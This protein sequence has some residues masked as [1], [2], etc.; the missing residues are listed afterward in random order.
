[1]NRKILIGPSSFAET[2][3]TPMKLLVATGYEVVDNPYK[4]RLTKQDLFK[5][6]EKNVV[7]L[8]AGVE[9]L[10]REVLERSDLK[11][12]SRVGS[13]L[14][15]I[16][17]K[18]AEQLGIRVFSTPHGP[19]SAVAELTLGAMLSLIRMVPQM[20]RAL[21]SGKWMK[22]TGSQLEGKTV[23]IIG[24][25]RIGRRVA[26]LLMPFK[27]KLVVVDPYLKEEP[28]NR[29]T[30]LPLEGA[31]PLAEIITIHSSGEA[32]ILTEREFSLM[33]Q[34]VFLLNAARGGLISEEALLKFIENGKIAGAWI[35]AFGEEPYSGPLCGFDNVI[36]TPH[37][38]SYTV[39]C[40]KAMETESVE[41]L[42]NALKE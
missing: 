12:I 41:N 25:G 37:I 33:K 13:G 16:D 19:T 11:V 20:D 42:I 28:N 10:D 32:C 21:H 34:G 36:L 23:A 35:D 31:L 1:V 14:S 15:N 8:I 7:G 30:R 38:G 6:L 2:D 26:E 24:F 39:E 3:K 22:K 9:P 17:L 18:A 29:Y 4:R 27:V 5:L 40:R